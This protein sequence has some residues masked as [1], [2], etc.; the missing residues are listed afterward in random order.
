MEASELLGSETVSAFDPLL[1]GDEFSMEN[2]YSA[3]RSSYRLSK[4]LRGL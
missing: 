4:L 3:T 2:G 1:C